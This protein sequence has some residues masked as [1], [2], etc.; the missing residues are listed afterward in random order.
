[1]YQIAL[2]LLSSTFLWQVYMPY[3]AMLNHSVLVLSCRRGKMI[4]NHNHSPVRVPN[5]CK[6]LLGEG[7]SGGRQY[8]SVTML[9]IVPRSQGPTRSVNPRVVALS[10]GPKSLVLRVSNGK[11]VLSLVYFAKISRCRALSYEWSR[12]HETPNR[13][14]KSYF[15]VTPR[16]PTR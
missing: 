16:G 4:L 13:R 9:S 5:S 11:K 3:V 2:L 14:L 7:G 10:Q 12:S 1:M 8:C 15:L 6:N